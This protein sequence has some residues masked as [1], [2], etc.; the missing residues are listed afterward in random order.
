MMT[1]ECV[2]KIDGTRLAILPT[3]LNREIPSTHGCLSH[4][5]DAVEEV[6]LII[7]RLREVR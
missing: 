6:S 1:I 4:V 2:V 7:I 5:V 3:R